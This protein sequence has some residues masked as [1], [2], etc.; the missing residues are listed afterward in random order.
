MQPNLEWRYINL[1]KTY[2]EGV[3]VINAK[4]NEENAK[5]I[6]N[7]INKIIKEEDGKITYKDFLGLKKNAYEIKGHKEGYYYFCRFNTMQDAKTYKGKIAIQ[8]NTIDE[9]IKFIIIEINN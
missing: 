1:E 4:K 3:F 7:K 2:Y 5:G 9:I 8:F 6:I